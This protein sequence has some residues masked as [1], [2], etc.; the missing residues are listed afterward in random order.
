MSLLILV[1]SSYTFCIL[2]F[3]LLCALIFNL[4]TLIPAGTERQNAVF[5]PL[6]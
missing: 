1:N 2:I 6:F 5:A 3:L 4:L